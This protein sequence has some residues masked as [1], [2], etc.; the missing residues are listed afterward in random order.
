MLAHEVREVDRLS[1]PN[2]QF[3]V[4]HFRNGISAND[5]LMGGR[6]KRGPRRKRSETASCLV[7]H[8]DIELE[9]EKGIR[10]LKRPERHLVNCGERGR[11][12]IYF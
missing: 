8:L 3:V 4:A 6:I 5:Q 11:L 2:H 10:S 7:K 12:Q 1:H 9:V